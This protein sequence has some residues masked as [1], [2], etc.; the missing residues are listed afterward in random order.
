MK[1]LL[2][3]IRRPAN[4]LESGGSAEVE[5]AVQCKK[6]GRFLTAK[7]LAAERGVC[8]CGCHM[9][10][11]ARERIRIT[12]DAGSFEELFGN[13]TSVDSLAFPGYGEKLARAKKASGENEGVLCGL[14]KIGGEK[15][16]LFV[17]EPNFMMGS[18]G[19]A[20]GE[21]LTRLFELARDERLHVVGF[22]ASGGARMQEGAQ[23]LMQMAKVSAAVR[24][25]DLQG[26]LFI[27]V[28]TDPTTGG[29]TASFATLGDIILAEP[30]ALIGFA[31]RRVV[32]QTTQRPLPEDFQSAESLLSCGFIDAIVPRNAMRGRLAALL[33][34]HR[35]GAKP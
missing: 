8:P 24:W 33:K 6:C 12:A 29:V 34:M 27:S 1:N 20:V 16:L 3:L 9:R 15:C 10:I 22:S 14:A 4:A 35:G 7:K 2:E 5:S 13:I 18:M 32:Q 31:G 25:H 19:A 21:K 11:S 17:M 26:G 23:S 28:L 30:G